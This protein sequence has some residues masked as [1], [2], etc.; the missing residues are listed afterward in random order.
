M[1]FSGNV[2]LIAVR[3]ASGLSERLSTP[4][5]WLGAARGLV[6]CCCAAQFPYPYGKTNALSDETMLTG[7]QTDGTDRWTD[8]TGR[9]TDRRVFCIISNMKKY[10]SAVRSTKNV[11]DQ[12]SALQA[13][14]DTSIARVTRCVCPRE[15]Y[16]SVA[17][18]LM[19]GSTGLRRSALFCARKLYNSH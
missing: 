3:T 1:Y 10:T 9:Q 15:G 4:R 19:P 6:L 7:R 18:L 8:Q 14:C 13:A 2:G 17:P 16:R 12:N 5:P 11:F